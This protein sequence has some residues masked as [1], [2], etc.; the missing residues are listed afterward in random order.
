MS[1]RIHKEQSDSGQLIYSYE[2]NGRKTPLNSLYSPEKEV[3][4]FLK[5]IGEMSQ[6]L[7]I[8]I[9]FGNGALVGGLLKSELYKKNIHFLFIEPFSEVERSESSLALFKKNKKFSFY[10]AKDFDTLIFTKY[11]VK[12]MSIPIS[13]QIH[14]NYSKLDNTV[15]NDCLKIIHEGIKTVEIFKNTQSHFALDWIIEP[16]LNTRS[17]TRASTISSYKDKFK[18]ERA[19]LVASGPSLK[20]HINFLE[21]N[22]DTFHIFSV[23]SALRALLVNNI[24]PDYTLSLDAGKVNYDTHFEDLNYD[25]TLIFETMSHSKIQDT[26]KGP[27]IASRT[28]A[29]QVSLLYTKDL[30]SFTQSSPSVAVLALQVIAYFGF[31]EIYFVGQDLALVDGDYYAAG[32]QHHD[33]VKTIKEEMFVENNQGQQIGTTQTLKLYLESF[34]ALIK[35]LPTELAI[36]NLSEYGAKIAGT[37]F[38]RES[39]IAK[40]SKSEIVV[41]EGSPVKSSVGAESFIRNFIIQL[42]DLQQELTGVRKRLRRL[43]LSGS[44]NSKDFSKALRGYREIKKRVIVEKIILSNLKFLFNGVS[45]K[46]EL[47]SYK[48]HYT[49]EEQIELLNEIDNFYLLAVT[50]TD[51]ILKDERLI[52]YK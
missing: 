31:S 44:V 50:F 10:Y 9:G 21:E 19:I 18:G 51:E 27:L 4:R 5:K 26:H 12:H 23:G 49:N 7:V 36:Y 17:L 1:Y 6:H 29:D 40:K 20:Q 35:T 8:M 15:M 2:K 25:G 37:T 28:I 52:Y 3:E 32:I 41:S 13:I 11:I 43:I 48:P 30:Y 33:V 39:E 42:Q 24:K 34:E 22:K 14:P 45:N 47:L 16:L 38:I 46:I